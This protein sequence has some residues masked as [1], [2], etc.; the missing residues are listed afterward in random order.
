M[1]KKVLVFESSRENLF[2]AY[3]FLFS[4]D[5]TSRPEVVFH[6]FIPEAMEMINGGSLSGVIADNMDVI[7]ACND[8][9]IPVVLSVGRG[10]V[11]S[12]IIN[13]RLE[14]ISSLLGTEDFTTSPRDWPNLWKKLLQI[15]G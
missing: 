6:C 1:K 9:G 11:G 8:C 15:M 10:D 2:A 4:I 13:S 3:K 12:S 14:E 5:E 7:E